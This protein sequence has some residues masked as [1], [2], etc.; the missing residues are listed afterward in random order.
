MKHSVNFKLI[1]N[2]VV[3]QVLI[4][5]HA[6]AFVLD[7]GAAITVLT[8]KTANALSLKKVKECKARGAGGEVDMNMVNVTSLSVGTASY[9]NFVGAVVDL[10]AICKKIG[11]EIDGILGIDFISRYKVTIDYRD[12]LLTLEEYTSN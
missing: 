8:E 12:C 11:E 5:G 7:T 10:A 1:Q 3:L 2:L 4:N 9:S 6:K